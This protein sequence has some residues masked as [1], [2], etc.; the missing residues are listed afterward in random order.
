LRRIAVNAV[1]LQPQMG[2][3]ETYV[4]SLLPALLEAK[5][6]L[7][8]SVFVNQS[9]KELLGREAW[10]DGVR[11]ITHPLLG[12]RYTRALTELTVLGRL[13]SRGG[14]DVLHSVALTG[15]L[16]TRPAHVLTVGDV[17]WIRHPD[18]SEQRTARLWRTIVPPVAR[19]AE[20]VLT[21]SEAS[22]AEI[23][24][25]LHVPLEQI[26]AVPLGPGADSGAEPTGEPELRSRLE[27]GSGPVV[28]AVSALKEHKNVGRLIEALAVVRQTVPDAVVVVPANPTPLQAELE[29]VAVRLGIAEAVVF[30]GWLSD[31]DLEGLYRC[32][33]CLAFPSLREGFGLP[34]LEAMRRGLPVACSNTSSLP[35]VGADAVLY[36]DPYRVE[37]IATALSRLL[38]DSRLAAELASEGTVRQRS[39]TWRRTAEET[40]AAYERALS[41]R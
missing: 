40:L 9:G 6:A 16:V 8:V 5:P 31:S 32:A 23:A 11:L 38:T 19:R 29:R 22:R 12:R 26:D 24:D 35:E 10:A 25:D 15:P 39:F 33:T 28:L 18:P 2:G 21:Y 13:A 1:F 41:R 30:P 37:E 17:T 14:F 20:L 27:L 4:R 3:I 7:E 34:I 36:F